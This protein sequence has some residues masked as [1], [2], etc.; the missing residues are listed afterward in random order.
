MSEL[1]HI[2]DVLAMHARHFPTRSARA[3]SIAR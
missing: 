2:G 1:A 3:I